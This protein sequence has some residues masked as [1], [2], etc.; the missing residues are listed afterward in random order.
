MEHVSAFF[1][2]SLPKQLEFQNNFP[3]GRREKKVDNEIKC[4]RVCVKNGNLDIE[5]SY[6]LHLQSEAKRNS[7][8][9][10]P[11]FVA[12]LFDWL[13]EIGEHGWQFH[14]W[15]LLVFACLSKYGIW[16]KLNFWFTFT[17]KTY[18]MKMKWN[19]G[20]TVNDKRKTRSTSN[21]NVW[22]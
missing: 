16:F 22:F 18:K 7:F 13:Y 4:T 10:V 8:A 2:S 19:K 12:R 6:I 1:W 17:M 5:H 20:A 15:Y 14:I 3:N 21:G 11:F 9:F